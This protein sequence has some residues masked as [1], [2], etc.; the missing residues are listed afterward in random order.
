MLGLTIDEPIESV[1]SRLAAR[2]V[3]LTGDVVRSRTDSFVEIEDQDGNA[4][5]LWEIATQPAP[6]PDLASKG[7]SS[8]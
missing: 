6:E 2:G 1:V 7:S 5:Y 3:R 8:A 4:I